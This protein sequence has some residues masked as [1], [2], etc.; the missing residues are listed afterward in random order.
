M[1]LV[2][3]MACV[4]WWLEMRMGSQCSFFVCLLTYLFVLLETCFTVFTNC[5]LKAVAFCMGVLAGLLLKLMFLFVCSGD[6]LLFVC[7][8]DILLFVCSG[9]ILLFV[10]S[11]DILLLSLFCVF[12]QV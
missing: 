6:I 3:F 5:L 11:V 8:G 2:S 1:F 9:D 12:Q 10:C 7:S 4:V